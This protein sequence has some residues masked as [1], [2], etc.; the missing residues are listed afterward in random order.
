MGR[1]GSTW[2]TVGL[3]VLAAVAGVLSFAAIQSTQGSVP[4]APPIPDQAGPSPVSTASEAVEGDGDGDG[5]DGGGDGGSLGDALPETLEPPLLLVSSTLVYRATTGSCLGGAELERST[6]GGKRWTPLISP[7]SA[8][9]SL[10]STG[11]ETL[12][13]V[14]ADSTCEVKVWTSTDQGAT[15][16]APTPASDVFV[17]DPDD[18][19]KLLTPAGTVKNPCP[20][21]Q[22]SPISVDG[23]SP[24][25]AA[26]LCATGDVVVTQDAG[27]T[28]ATQSPVVGGVA[29]TFESAS[30]GWA[31]RLNS[32]QCPSFQLMRTQ[33]GAL[34]WQTGGCLGIDP[35]GDTAGTASV[36]FA[37]PDSGIADL[38][39]AVYATQ[40]SGLTWQ[41][42]R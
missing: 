4:L 3:I 19:T 11:G 37:D 36:S 29:M 25:E 20:D 27:S 9:L 16:S 1:G 22:E 35:E 38:A 33:D 10:T 30:L 5:G 26:V 40:D 24:T 18:A 41:G 34:T 13:M 39:G 6:N 12:T 23:T 2:T 21:A 14:G 7:A 31:L 42:P 8:T 15:W 17:R 32:G 28:W